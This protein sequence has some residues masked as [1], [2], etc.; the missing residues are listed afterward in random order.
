MQPGLCQREFKVRF[1]FGADPYVDFDFYSPIS[2]ALRFLNKR[3][4]TGGVIVVDDYGFFSSGAKTAVDEFLKE[5][6]YNSPFAPS[7]SNCLN[8]KLPIES[9][10]QPQPLQDVL[11]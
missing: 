2:V 10:T 1:Y 9:S 3:L 4:V 6:G 8:F 11:L 7:I 5:Y